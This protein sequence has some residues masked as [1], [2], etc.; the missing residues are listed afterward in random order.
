MFGYT[1]KEAIGKSCLDLTVP[2]DL[3]ILAEDI[4][5]DLIAQKGES[6]NVNETLTKS[7]KIIICHW[8]NTLIKDKNKQVIGII[9]SV[10]DITE[11]ELARKELFKKQ[12]FIKK[13]L[14][15][16]LKFIL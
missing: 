9:S 13:R 2:K 6:D 8:H 4:F 7:G 12:Q 14:K 10:E 15:N 5:K 3:K 11:K 1:A 16:F